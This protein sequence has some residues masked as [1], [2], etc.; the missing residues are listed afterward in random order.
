MTEARVVAVWIGDQRDELELDEYMM[1]RFES[2]FGFTINDRMMPEIDT[3]PEP[4]P[5]A[6]LLKHFSDSKRWIG[7]AVSKCSEMGI[8]AATSAVVFPFLRFS[9]DL[10]PIS[11]APGL[12]FIGNF[13]WQENENGSPEEGGKASPATS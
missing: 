4:S 5:V 13:D 3:R 1:D 2:D 9:T 12:R 7:A 11:A 10:C 6:E 8:E